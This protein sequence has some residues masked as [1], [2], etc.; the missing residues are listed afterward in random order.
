MKDLNA[1]NAIGAQIYRVESLAENRNIID[2]FGIMLHFKEVRNEDLT[3]ETMQID[4]K[5]DG[6]SCE[7]PLHF[8]GTY[9]PEELQAATRNRTSAKKGWDDH[10]VDQEDPSQ[11][12]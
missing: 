3:H 9:F 6:V 5:K 7:L 4:N 10:G 1:E 2:Q 11:E 8:K 12:I